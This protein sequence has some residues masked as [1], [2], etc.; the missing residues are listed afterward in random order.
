MLLGCEDFFDLLCIGQI[1]LGKNL[2][3]LQKTPL[4]WVVAGRVPCDQGKV[5]KANA[6]LSNCFPTQDSLNEK[7]ERFWLVKEVNPNPRAKMTRE[8]LECESHFAQTTTRDED[9]RFVVK[10][11]LKNNFMELGESEQSAL[12]R[13]YSVERRLAKYTELGAAYR[14][15]MREY[16]DLGH[17]TEIPRQL[18]STKTPVYYIPHHCVEK[19]ESTTT[20]LRVVFDAACKT[21]KD[22]SLNDVLKVGPTIQNDVF[23]VLLRFRKHTFVLIG[24]LAK[25]YRQILVDKDE[26]NLQRIVWRD[27]PNEEI[28]H[29]QLNTVT[30]GTASA[31]YLS[32][33]C[34]LEISSNV[35]E[36]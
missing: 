35:A 15:F 17:M 11:P 4:G 5:G 6:T 18:P 26:R 21:T 22:L 8:E 14:A 33:Q 10:L 28:K 2:P 9:G 7:L 3:I 12:S 13:L 16:Q 25:M 31:S 19:P 20:K 23:S 27:T 29:F 34:L 30:Y 36:Q 1:K 32:T 24:D